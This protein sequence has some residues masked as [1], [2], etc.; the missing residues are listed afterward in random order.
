MKN[1]LFL[2][3]SALG[4]AIVGCMVPPAQQGGT[5]Y[6]SGGGY[7]GGSAA[8][9]D[10]NTYCSRQA[11]CGVG[12]FQPCS[13]YCS[14]NAGDPYFAQQAIDMSDD[15]C[16][17]LY[18]KAEAAQQSGGGGGGG[19]GGEVGSDGSGCRQSAASGG[20]PIQDCPAMQ[21]CCEGGCHSISYC[22]MPSGR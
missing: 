14:A 13:D 3:L 7:E 8:G 2:I 1:G 16:E 17:E 10:C 18:S 9:L 4:A 20:T 12:D 15:S 21:K 22:S 11:E 19:G 6:Q 5:G